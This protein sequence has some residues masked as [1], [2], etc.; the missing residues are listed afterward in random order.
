MEKFSPFS[1]AEIKVLQQFA[2]PVDELSDEE[3][4]ALHNFVY[5]RVKLRDKNRDARSRSKFYIGQSVYWIHNGRNYKGEILKINARTVTVRSDG[6]LWK[7]N[8]GFLSDKPI[9]GQP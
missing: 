9:N 5:Q 4:E 8:A 6:K 3:L 2:Q 7:I 1:D